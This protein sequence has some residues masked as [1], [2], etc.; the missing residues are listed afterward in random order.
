MTPRS[1]RTVIYRSRWVC[2]ASDISGQFVNGAK[3]DKVE[4]EGRPERCH[5]GR[6]PKPV[7]SGG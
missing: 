4:G 1:R 2:K 5:Q 6:P 3:S 7:A